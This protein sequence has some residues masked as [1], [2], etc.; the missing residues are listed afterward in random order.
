MMN[1][2]FWKKGEIIDSRLR[3]EDWT[4]PKIKNPKIHEGVGVIQTNRYFFY[5]TLHLYRSDCFPR[6]YSD[7]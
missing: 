5:E 6:N 4:A 2:E 7:S 1:K 3:Y